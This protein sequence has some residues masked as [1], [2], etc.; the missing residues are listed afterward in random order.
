PRYP[1]AGSG[2]RTPGQHA[3]SGRR[4]LA[5]SAGA[6]PGLPQLRLAP[7][8]SAPAVA[9][10]RSHQWRW[11]SKGVESVYTGDGSGITPAR[12]VTQRGPVLSGTPVVPAADS[13]KHGAG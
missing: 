6:V 13:L 8:E 1:S 11:L 12:V 4:E 3:V 10:P 2:R 7:R 5:G 9:G